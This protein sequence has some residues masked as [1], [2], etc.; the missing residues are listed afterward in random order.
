MAKYKSRFAALGFYV[1]GRLKRFSDGVYAT[2]DADEIAVLDRLADAVRV[3]EVS[4]QDKILNT[5]AVEPE[6]TE[7]PKSPRKGGTSVK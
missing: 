1:N 2:E 4:A 3:D 5:E 6:T 7:K